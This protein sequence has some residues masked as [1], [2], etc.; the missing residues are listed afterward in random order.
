MARV[1]RQDYSASISRTSALLAAVAI[2]EDVCA[3]K[4]MPADSV[5]SSSR[6]RQL[7]HW[8][9]GS[10]VEYVEQVTPTA[11]HTSCVSAARSG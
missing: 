10:A 2:M 4:A 3:E 11:G 9:L 7:Q 6:A 8:S 1:R 5:R